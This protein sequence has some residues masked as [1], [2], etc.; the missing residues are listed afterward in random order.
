M[1]GD[2]NIEMG[3]YIILC[4]VRMGALEPRLIEIISDRF[5]ELDVSGDGTLDYAEIL[6][7]LSE[8]PDQLRVIQD[9]GKEKEVE[10]TTEDQLSV[11]K[12]ILSGSVEEK[13]NYG[14]NIVKII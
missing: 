3:E 6:E 4:A 5:A 8:L 12:S 11:G 7:D 13:A 10:Q 14:D 1:L 2:G 9:K